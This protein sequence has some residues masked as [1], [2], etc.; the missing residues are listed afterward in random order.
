[1]QYTPCH[2]VQYMC[3]VHLHCAELSSSI[4]AE[5]NMNLTTI[6]VGYKRFIFYCQ[7]IDTL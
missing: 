5:A 2:Q 4:L 6:R 7:K 3:A 1:M